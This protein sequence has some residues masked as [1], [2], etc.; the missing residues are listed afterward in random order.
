MAGSA[1]TFFTCRGFCG[2]VFFFFYLIYLTWWN[3]KHWILLINSY[4]WRHTVHLISLYDSCSH[5]HVRCT[6]MSWWSKSLENQQSFFDFALISVIT[7]SWRDS[8]TSHR[9]VPN[10]EPLSSLVALHRNVTAEFPS[11]RL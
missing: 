6:R 7:K 11:Q 10:L 3:C 5:A 1:A 2:F 8:S 4:Q 9:Y